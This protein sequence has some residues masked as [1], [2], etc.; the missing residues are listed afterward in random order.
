MKELYQDMK[1][2][3][4]KVYLFQKMITSRLFVVIYKT[5]SQV[6]SMNCLPAPHS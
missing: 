5:D 2:K 6:T 3:K 4:N 1:I